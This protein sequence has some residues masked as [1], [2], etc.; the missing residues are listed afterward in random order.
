MDDVVNVLCAYGDSDEVC[1]DA[2][3]G[4]L[5]IAKLL[6]RRRPGVYSQSLGVADAAVF[7]APDL[8]PDFALL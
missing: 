3:V 5:L 6:M 1:G 2:A 4:L 7:L 8:A